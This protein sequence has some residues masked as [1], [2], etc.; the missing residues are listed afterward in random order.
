MWLCQ[1]IKQMP[2]QM[3]SRRRLL[4]IYQ[5][6]RLNYEL[7]S[8]PDLFETHIMIKFAFTS[9]TEEWLLACIKQ[10]ILNVLAEI[11]RSRIFQQQ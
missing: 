8:H 3:Y 5:H 2:G 11:T 10:N 1:L 6:Y 4:F 7:L 9:F